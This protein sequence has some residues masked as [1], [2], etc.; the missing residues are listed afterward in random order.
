[1]RERAFA[2]A[3]AAGRRQTRGL[4]TLFTHPL[5]AVAGE[6]EKAARNGLTDWRGHTGGA[7]PLRLR[8]PGWSCRAAWLLWISDGPVRRA[9]DWAFVKIPD[10]PI[11]MLYHR[12]GQ[13]Y[14]AIV[15]GGV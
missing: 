5:L 11:E 8:L 13:G 9:T 6:A 1:M 7:T 4:P 12:R 2:G 3:R 14:K 15:K 10:A